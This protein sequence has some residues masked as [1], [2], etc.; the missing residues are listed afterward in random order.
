VARILS[1]LAIVV[2][3][4]GAFTSGLAP[5]LI[6]VPLALAGAVWLASDP[7]LLMTVSWLGG[8]YWDLAAGGWTVFKVGL[9]AQVGL[10]AVTA[11]LGD[12]KLRADRVLI[13]LTVALASWMVLTETVATNPTLSW[14][15]QLVGFALILLVPQQFVHGERDLQRFATTASLAAVP[16]A[17]WVLDELNWNPTGFGYARIAGPTHQPNRM[18]HIAAWYALWSAALLLS[19]RPRHLLIGAF[20]LSTMIYVTLASASRGALAMLVTGGAVFWLLAPISWT[21]RLAFAGGIVVTVV[22]LMPFLPPVF[23]GRVVTTLEAAAD[24][25]SVGKRELAQ[26]SAGRDV[27]YELGFEM[28]KESPIL[29]H[30][31]AEFQRRNHRRTFGLDAFEA[32]SGVVALAAAHGL[33]A[34]L[35]VV[36]LFA[37]TWRAAWIVCRRG[38]TRAMRT[39]GAVLSGVVAME[40]VNLLNT[41]APLDANVWLCPALAVASARIV[42]RQERAARRGAQHQTAAPG[43]RRSTTAGA[44][45]L[46]PPSPAGAVP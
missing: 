35:I 19:R 18:G 13:M 1:M 42:R 30:G 7:V 33:P 32:H 29:G 14:G 25:T 17:L 10:I 39:Y 28:L 20:G 46:S 36:L 12:R 3:A 2:A 16:L 24:P 6:G 5:L 22:A 41:T 26:L 31:D 23:S 38:Q 9:I 45:G 11:T 15:P 27:S 8:E 34:L 21:R 37:Y 40:V 44:R 43:A 4:F